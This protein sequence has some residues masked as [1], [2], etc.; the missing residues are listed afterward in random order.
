MVAAGGDRHLVYAS[1]VDPF[2]LCLFKCRT[3]SGAFD[4][5]VSDSCG[6][7]LGAAAMSVVIR[8]PGSV[9]HENTYRSRDHFCFGGVCPRLSTDSFRHY[10]HTEFGTSQLAWSHTPQRE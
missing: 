3:G 2:D 4:G 9:V 5:V 1:V 7:N 8:M 10:S 6:A